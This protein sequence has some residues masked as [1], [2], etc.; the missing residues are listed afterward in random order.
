[1]GLQVENLVLNNRSTLKQLLGISSEDV[2]CE[3][4]YFQRQ[5][6]RNRGRKIDSSKPYH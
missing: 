1:M 6:L 2:L 5:T 3:G 4:P